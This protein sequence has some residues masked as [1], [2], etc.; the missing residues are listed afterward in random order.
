MDLGRV[1]K[2]LGI[3][4]LALPP[5]GCGHGGLD[6]HDV[7]Q[8]IDSAFADESSTQVLLFEPVG[9]PGILTMP[10]RTERPKMTAGRAALVAIM[11]RYQDGLLDPFVSLLEIHKLMYFLQ[12]AGQP[13]RLHYE[14]K[15]FGPYAS[16]LRQVLIKI[17]GHFLRGYG[18]GQDNPTK[19]IEIIERAIAEAQ[20]YVERDPAL[21]A[22]MDRVSSLIDGFEDPYGMELLSSMHWV[23]CR[24]KAARESV[25]QAIAL[26]HDWNTRKRDVLKPDHLTKAW[27]RLKLQRWDV[28]AYGVI[29]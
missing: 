4:S 23:M 11:K 7:R 18:D 28:D 1:A 9:V 3:T 19:P 6:W 20:D 16:N 29:H 25:S 14:A 26:V 24:D 22:R 15:K 5:L 27:N 21:L 13:L 17:E 8:L 2:Q 12:E 10:N